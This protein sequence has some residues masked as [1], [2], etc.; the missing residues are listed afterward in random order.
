MDLHYFGPYPEL[1]TVA[2]VLVVPVP[3]PPLA[4]LPR[5]EA[6]VVLGLAIPLPL[7]DLAG[8]EDA[9]RGFGKSWRNEVTIRY[10]KKL[11]GSSETI[12]ETEVRGKLAL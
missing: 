5:V 12:F 9:A 1:L 11:K 6:E 8:I 2:L 4:V 10:P 7:V 3:V